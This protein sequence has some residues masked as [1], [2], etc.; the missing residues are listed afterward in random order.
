MFLGR[1]S[2]RGEN[3]FPPFGERL[4]GDFLR[5][6]RG[7]DVFHLATR[8]PDATLLVLQAY[9]QHGS[10]SPLA[11]HP[12]ASSYFASDY[13]CPFLL[14]LQMRALGL[15]RSA[16]YRVAEHT[17]LV[18][19]AEQLQRQDALWYWGVLPLSLI[20]EE[21]ARRTAVEAFVRRGASRPFHADA[22]RVFEQCGV[23]L[24]WL[25]KAVP[26]SITAD[27]ERANAPSMTTLA[28]LLQSLREFSVNG[29]N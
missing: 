7:R 3:A 27:E 17:A 28:M 12:C 9:S 13:F 11:L 2:T 10:L 1:L 8:F 4:S 19:F 25:E 22:K 14:L 6:Q 16:A 26:E 5:S 18:G 23:C 21:T 15:P 24:Q 29:S 20:E